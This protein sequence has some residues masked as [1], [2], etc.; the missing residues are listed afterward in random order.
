MPSPWEDVGSGRERG[1]G[2]RYWEASAEG[3]TPLLLEQQV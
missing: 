3:D 1:E 2:G